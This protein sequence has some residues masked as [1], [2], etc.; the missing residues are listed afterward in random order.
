MELTLWADNT[1]SLNGTHVGSVNQKTG[2]TRVCMA[3]GSALALPENRYVLSMQEGSG[4]Y[5][6]SR[7]FKVDVIMALG[8][9][10]WLK[11][12]GKLNG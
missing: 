12:K 7:Q 10:G 3:D 9:A 5:P 2:G 6:G 4:A 1:L 8:K 11:E